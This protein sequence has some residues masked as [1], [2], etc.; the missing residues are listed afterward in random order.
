MM[1]EYSI[2]VD[3]GGTKVAYGLFDRQ[4]S[5]I[6]RSVSPSQPLLSFEGMAKSMVSQIDKLIEEANISK[7]EVFGIGIGLPGQILPMAGR[8]ATAP[9]LRNWTNAPVR[10]YFSKLSGLPVSIGNDANVAALA[11]YRMGAGRGSTN[12]A[13]VTIST[14]VGCGLILEGRLYR[15]SYSAA[16][17][18]G[19]MFVT[20][21]ND[22]PCG[23]GRSSCVEALSSGTGMTNY[24]VA[25]MREDSYLSQYLR[26]DARKI[27]AGVREGDAFSTEILDRC[28]EGLARALYNLYTLLNLDRVVI[29]GGVSNIG[30]LLLDRVKERF[31]KMAPLAYEYPMDIVMSELGGDVGIIGA[32]FLANPRYTLVRA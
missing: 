5:L 11:E 20:D 9:N 18:L 1:K 2:G 16:G 27:E 25:H 13:Y 23:C 10:D 26:P 28:A 7:E 22:V 3:V 15:G 31:Y 6:G 29:G 8:L 21:V 14:G 12:M 4:H 30:D 19:H 32:G 17:E 24:A